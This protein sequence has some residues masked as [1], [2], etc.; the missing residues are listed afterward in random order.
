VRLAREIK[1]IVFDLDDTLVVDMAAADAAFL[2]TAKLAEERCGIEPQAMV[3]AVRE[4]ARPIWH[5]SPAREYCLRVGP[6]SWE[7]LWARYEGNDPSVKILRDWAPTYRLAAWSA[8]LAQFNIHDP[9]LALTL[10]EDFP[11][12]RRQHHRLFPDAPGV[13]RALHGAFKLGLMTNGL[14]C[15][16]REKIEGVGIAPYFEAMA[17][18]GDLGIGKPHP[19]I[20]HAVLTPLDVRPE[21][22]LMV[23]NSIKG[24][25]GGA[26][27]VGMKAILIDR[28]DPH[29]QDD[30]IKPDAVM[31]QLGEVMNYLGISGPAG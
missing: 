26:Q 23:G 27:A 11:V 19:A 5:A 15:L 28:G 21:Q 8:A 6:S 4:Q 31:H 14:S 10:A 3:K 20:F 2:E 12:R 17:I 1:A 22:A 18:S 24:D 7:G 25:I 13:L 9:A 29:G 16:Q 30:T